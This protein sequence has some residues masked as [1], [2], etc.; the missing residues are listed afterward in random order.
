MSDLVIDISKTPFS[1]SGCWLSLTHHPEDH[2]IDLRNC[3][4]RFDDD[5]YRLTFWRD[6]AAQ[7]V[8]VV[9]TPG[10]VLVTVVGGGT[11][12]L[13][14]AG[15][16]RLWVEAE[17][18][19][20]RFAL[21]AKFA[22]G[23]PE[24]PGRFKVISNSQ[25]FCAAFDVVA[26]TA[27]AGGPRD[28]PGFAVGPRPDRSQRCDITVTGQR[29][30]LEVDLGQNEVPPQRPAAA[31]SVATAAADTLAE[32]RRFLAGLPAVPTARRAAAELAWYNLWSATV[33]AEGHYRCPSILMSKKF[34]CS[35][36]SWDCLLYTSPSPRDH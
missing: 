20:L 12:R 26:G 11:A 2:A 1:R 30:A 13:A 28:I 21:R 17:G 16:T 3:R 32:W 34:M 19:E 35:V 22:Y 31:V 4:R 5:A 29:L 9:A 33:P 15:S 18:V 8:T 27:T 6:G 10:Q 25:H 7:P 14:F 24:G 23:T 36:W